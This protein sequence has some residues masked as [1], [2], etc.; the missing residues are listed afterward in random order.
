MGPGLDSFP[1]LGGKEAETGNNCEPGQLCF[2]AVVS[3]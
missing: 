1:G 3:L 2:H